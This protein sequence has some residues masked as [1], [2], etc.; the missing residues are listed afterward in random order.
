VVLAVN[1][2]VSAVDIW[3]IVI[4][5]VCC[6]AFWLG[7]VMWADAHPDIRR[8]RQLPDMPG[9][10]IGGMHV[11]EDGGRSVSPNREAPPVLRVPGQ[12]SAEPEPASGQPAAG[13]P[14]SGQ[15]ASGQPAEGQPAPGLASTPAQRSGEA[16]RP[17]RSTASRGGADQRE[18]E[19]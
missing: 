8:T 12:R 13:Q 17:E 5:A 7:A 11:A 3:A 10:V 4:V 9:P 18:D 14:A 15:P 19:S 1:T 2:T 6:L 16:D